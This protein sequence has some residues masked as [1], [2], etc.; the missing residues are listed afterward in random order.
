[1]LSASYQLSLSKLLTG[2]D[3]RWHAGLFAGPSV[4]TDKHIGVHAGVVVDYDIDR[5]WG[6]SYQHTLYVLS[7]SR[8]SHAAALPPTQLPSQLT[9]INSFSV[10]V[11]RRF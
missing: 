9:G 2:R 10:G 6:L 8:D 4:T 5:H 11:T 7:K 1:M 3:S